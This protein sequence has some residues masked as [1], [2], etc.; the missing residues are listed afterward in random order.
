MVC[1][2]LRCRINNR[3]NNRWERAIGEEVFCGVCSG[4]G[5]CASFMSA[6]DRG[7][8]RDRFGDDDAIAFFGEIDEGSSMAQE[9]LF[10]L[11]V[12]DTS[13]KMDICCAVVLRCICTEVFLVRAVS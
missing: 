10:D 3:I 1:C 2:V 5:G 7:V 11:R 4:E 13:P 12:S 8:G 9:R 6:D